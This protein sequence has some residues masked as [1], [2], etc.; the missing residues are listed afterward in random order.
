MNSAKRTILAVMFVLAMKLSPALNGPL[1]SLDVQEYL[2]I[3]ESLISS[4][5][6]DK[7]TSREATEYVECRTVQID[8]SV[9]KYGKS[10]NRLK[11]VGLAA[12]PIYLVLKN[13]EK[14]QKGYESWSATKQ[15]DDTKSITL[16][17]HMDNVEFSGSIPI[18]ERHV[19]LINE[20]EGLY[21]AC[22]LDIPTRMID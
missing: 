19:W 6:L 5:G 10:G 8:L 3:S 18:D 11:V 15:N 17:F 7:T 21:R 2:F 12:E 1:E 9:L 22:L 16:S 4:Q 20:R 13:R 14:Y